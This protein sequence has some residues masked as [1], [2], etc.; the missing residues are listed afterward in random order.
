MCRWVGVAGVLAAFVGVWAT[1]VRA[2][3]PLS[4]PFVSPVNG[5]TYY[6]LTQS[7]WT[8]A[9][10]AARQLG[11][12]LATVRSQAENDWIFDTFGAW[13]GN[14][15]HLWI[16]LTD[17]EAFGGTEFG[18]TGGQPYP[19]GGNRGRG[20]VWVGGEPVT[21]QN[22]DP[23]NPDNYEGDDPVHGEDYAHMANF[24]GL[25]DTGMWND[26]FNRVEQE[27]VGV[28][29]FHGVAEVVP[30]PGGAAVLLAAAV[31]ALLPRRR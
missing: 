5:H 15:R 13:G 6:L 14:R 3:D 24:E 7:N 20:W 27:F 10:A 30:E 31:V 23:G 8:D 18:E 2:A 29:P 21:F 1:P 17:D 9:E 16:G 28:V 25:S 19:P 11:G 4:G 22:W 26:N 12:H